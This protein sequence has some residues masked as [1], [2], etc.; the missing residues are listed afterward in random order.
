[1][2]PLFNVIL[3]ANVQTYFNELFQIA[4]FD[5]I[6]TDPAVNWILD[7]NQTQP[8]NPKFDSLGFSST[9]FLNNLGT[10]ALI[11][12]LYLISLLVFLPIDKLVHRFKW[13]APLHH[14]LKKSLFYN[15]LTGMLMESCL[16]LCVCAMINLEFASWSTYGKAI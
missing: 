16:L 3:P 13:L 4:S 7:L 10:L 11:F 5:F 15:S 1:M 6:N 14:K 12:M 9:F 8:L 2:M